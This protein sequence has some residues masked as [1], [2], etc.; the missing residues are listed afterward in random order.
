MPR[1]LFSEHDGLPFRDAVRVNHHYSFTVT[2]A[3]ISFLLLN[4]RICD[5]KSFRIDMTVL[6]TTWVIWKVSLRAANIFQCHRVSDAFKPEVVGALDGRCIDLQALF[7]GA[8][9]TGLSLE[10]TILFLPLLQV[11]NLGLE[12]R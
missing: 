8:L 9:G 11:W 3:E 1:F 6:I 4:R 5:I 7:Y 10:F 12:R 2:L